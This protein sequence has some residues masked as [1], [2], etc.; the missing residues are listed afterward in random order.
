MM[1]HIQIGADHLLVEVSIA[2]ALSALAC[3]LILTVWLRFRLTG[4]TRS[5]PVAIGI[6]LD[7]EV[8]SER[9][10]VGPWYRPVVRY[11]YEIAG[12]RF[13]GSHISWTEQQ[14]R[15]Y[16]KARMALDSF[17]P[18][19]KVNVYYDPKMPNSAVLNPSRMIAVP[20]ELVIA[21]TAVMYVLLIA[22]PL[23]LAP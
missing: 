23:F 1:N 5:W 13:E 8:A 22:C 17:S 10:D 7:R 4:F 16:A 14:H 15:T 18:G 2:S 21:S 11:R 6:L 20:A 3:G 9:D 12:Q 19:Q